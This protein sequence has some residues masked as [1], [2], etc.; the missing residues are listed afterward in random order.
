M[1]GSFRQSMTWLHTWAGLIF[2]WILYFMFVTGT[3]GY[4]DDEID[5]WMMPE[6][7]AMQLTSVEKSIATAVPFLEQEASDA[8][9]WFIALATDRNEPLLRVF[10]NTPAA[11]EGGEA[12]NDNKLLD[13]STGTAVDESVNASGGGQVLY[14]MHYILHYID[15]DLAYRLIGVLTFLMFVG[16]VSGIVAHKKIFKDFFT[17]RTSKGQR[18]WL[19]MH[20]L[21]SVSTLPFQIMITYSGLIFMIVTW[22]PG[23][24]LGTYGFDAKKLQADGSQLLGQTELEKSGEAA[25]LADL[26]A[27]AKLAETRLGEGNIAG[28]NIEYPGDANA[29]ITVNGKSAG[30]SRFANRVVFDGTTGEITDDSEIEL[31]TSVNIAATAIGLHEGL[32]AGTLLRWLY[33]LSGLLGTAMVAT[34]AIYWTIKRRPADGSKASFA[35]RFVECVNIGTIVGLLIAVA[36]YFWANRLLPEDLANRADWE[37]H[38]MFIVWA[39]TLLYPILRSASQA[40]RELT[41][42]AAFSYAAL[43]LISVFTVEQHLFNFSEH[44]RWTLAGFELTCLFTA[45]ALL[46]ASRYIAKPTAS[47]EIDKE[48]DGSLIPVVGK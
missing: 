45:G 6:R 44:G 27:V 17:F 32:F 15:R 36:A 4:F 1:I 11:E 41:W 30:L 37:V 18:S 20:N 22:M 5:Q 31:N 39:L 21:L 19:D 46:V 9:R 48:E 12:T 38:T 10:W 35:Y 47:K 34:G 3:L 43:P 40:W 23:I 25:P 33:F 26:T 7:P 2:C 24:A 28:F 8:S 14:R 42:L 29:R 16:I 13:V